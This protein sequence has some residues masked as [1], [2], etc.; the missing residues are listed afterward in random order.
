[1]N[2]RCITTLLARVYT[3]F[4]LEAFL[5]ILKKNNSK[6]ICQYEYFIFISG[7]LKRKRER[8]KTDRNI[9]QKFFY[10]FTIV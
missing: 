5:L 10:I 2:I 1:M 4:I 8:A 9:K 7:V 6:I 3:A